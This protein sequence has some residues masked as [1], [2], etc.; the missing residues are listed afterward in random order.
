MNK[1]LRI[2]QH[3]F[4]LLLLILSALLA[5]S[6]YH[7]LRRDMVLFKNGEELLARQDF[8]G[9][10]PVLSE[11]LRY[12][13]SSP[14]LWKSLGD[15]YLGAGRFQ[16][17]SHAYRRFLTEL[18][19]DRTVRISLARSLARN[20]SYDESVIEYRKVIGENP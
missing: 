4:F 15:A 14:K 20:G 11:S 7:R 12:G 5:V 9:A 3:L 1:A 10:I 17:A 16:D 13:N 19:A 2:R 18:P 8:Q 6:G